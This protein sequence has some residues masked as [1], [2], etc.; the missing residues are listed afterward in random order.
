MT[1]NFPEAARSKKF[2]YKKPCFSF[3]E[4]FMNIQTAIEQVR[5]SGSRP[6]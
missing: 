1:G 3:R 5:A 4:V 6:R 2:A